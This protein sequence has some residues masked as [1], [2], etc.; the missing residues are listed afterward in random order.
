MI[1]YFNSSVFYNAELTIQVLLHKLG[2]HYDYWNRDGCA[3]NLS[4]PIL[5]YYRLINVSNYNG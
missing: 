3:W 5:S 4:M 1:L 2:T